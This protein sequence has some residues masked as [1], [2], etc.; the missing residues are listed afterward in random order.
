[1]NIALTGGGT[2]GHVMPNMALLDDLYK[3]FDKVIYIG[4]KDK[5]EY[6]ICKKFNVPFYHCDC[7]KLDRSKFSKNLSIPIKLPKYIKEAKKILLEHNVDVVFSKGG[8]VAMPVVYAAK[9]LSIPTVCHES[10]YSLG[11]AN[12]L[13]SRFAKG[14][15][16]CFDC[17]CNNQKTKVF[18]NPIRKDFFDTH[19][20]SVFDNYG[21]NHFTPVLL[22]MGGSLGAK[23]I[24]DV[25][26]SSLDELCRKYQVIHICGNTMEPIEHKNY[27][28][29]K[30]T[31]DIQNYISAS[32]LIVS[33]CGAGASTEINALNKKALY[34]PLANKSSRGDQVLNARYLTQNGYALMLEEKQLTKE[35]LLKKL[36][37][38]AD[39]DKKVYVYDRNNNSKIVDYVSK[40][41]YQY[42]LTNSHGA[43]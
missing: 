42:A 20:Q 23:A 7:I 2:A 5:M 27:I 15:I 34:I 33:R 12:K 10:D 19:P 32:D 21:L 35:S 39:F 37:Q 28:Q 36:D 40:I 6:D 26:Y 18:A 22:I 38:L 14:I 3:Q 31:D 11:L 8:Y 17:T 29:I 1:M 13:N 16:T 43:Y 9:S 30:Y 4:N 24:N 25:V 41:A